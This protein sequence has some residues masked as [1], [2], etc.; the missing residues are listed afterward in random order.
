MKTVVFDIEC[1]LI[2][3]TTVYA[4]GI[5]DKVFTVYPITGSDGNLKQAE[6]ILEDADAYVFHNGIGYDTPTLRRLRGMKLEGTPIDTMII[7]KLMLSKDQL[8]DIDRG[9]E[10]MPKKLWGS[11]SLGAFG[12]RLDEHKG[13]FH[14]FSRLSAK[15]VTYCKQ[16]VNLTTKL[17]D[18]AKS[19]ENYPLQKVIDLEMK[20]ATLIQDQTEVGFH[21]NYEKARELA[22]KMKL[23]LIK[24][25]RKVHSIFTPKFLPDGPI[26]TAK[27]KFK[28]KVWLEDNA[29]T[30]WTPYTVYQ[31][32]WALRK[33]GKV[34]LPKKRIKWSD[35]PMRFVIQETAAEYQ[36]IK[37]QK[38]NINSRTQ[39]KIWL[40]HDIG[41]KFPYYT[42]KGTPKV[43]PDS[44]ENMEHESGKLLKRALKL[45]KDLSQL[46]TGSGSLIGNYNPETEAIHSRTDTNGTVTGR[47]TSSN[48][49]MNQIPAQKEFRELFDAPEGWTFVGTDFS[50]Q[51]NVNLAE[52]LYPYDNGRLADIIAKGSKDE[53][54]DL[55]SMNAKATGVSRTNA[56]PLWF[57]FLYGSSPT[58]TGYTLLGDGDFTDFTQKEWD[59]ADEKIRKRLENIEGEWL[60]PIKKGTMV[61]YTEQLI[62]QALYG[63]QVQKKLIASTT[64]LAELIHDLSAVAEEKGYVTM[65][66]G[67]R[68]PIRHAHAVLNSQLQGMGAEAVKYYVVEVRKRCAAMNLKHGID[69]KQQGV[70]YDEM[71]FIVKTESTEA[72]KTI[73]LESYATISEQL[74]MVVPYTGEVL[75]GGQDG[76]SN[77]WWGCH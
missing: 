43:D 30:M 57:G 65:H 26:K 3:S 36:P 73:L 39:I 55:H 53:G 37:Y 11:Y 34:K 63:A 64:G 22:T 7:L 61:P 75:L 68:V 16:D 70:I 15:M 67:R 5:D 24:L 45:S 8:Y 51:E 71:D 52:M 33:N 13:D 66:G 32:T 12:Y 41:Y 28:R 77:D 56:K 31:P 25:E 9:I 10:G 21:F 2:P 6:D 35:T 69:F 1:D 44:L 60:Y 58:L 17:Y 49:N 29:F 50:G 62:R 74:G 48:V 40:E 72:F 76:R 38:L 54:T 42:E 4:I 47:F 23:E 19:Q 46:M 18:W 27:A 20:V 59:K 14:D